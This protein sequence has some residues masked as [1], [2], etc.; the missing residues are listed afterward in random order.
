M[1]KYKLRAP[2]SLIDRLG[3]DSNPGQLTGNAVAP[4]LLSYSTYSDH[5]IE[6]PATDFSHAVVV[7]KHTSFR[8]GIAAVGP[9]VN[10][11]S[12]LGRSRYLLNRALCGLQPLQSHRIIADV[13]YEFLSPGYGTKFIHIAP[14]GGITMVGQPNRSKPFWNGPGRGPRTRLTEAKARRCC[15]GPRPEPR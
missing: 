8:I 6:C 12:H 10:Q 2:T 15:P 4:G 11:C 5:G 3:S 14:T 9:F 7:T 13:R 1:A